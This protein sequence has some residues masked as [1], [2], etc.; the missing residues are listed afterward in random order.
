MSINTKLYIISIADHIKFKCPDKLL[1]DNTL[2]QKTGLF[3]NTVPPNKNDS[4][5]ADYIKFCV[6]GQSLKN[7]YELETIRYLINPSARHRFTE[8]DP[9]LYKDPLK[10][11]NKQ[12][13]I[14]SG[15]PIIPF[16]IENMPNNYPRSNLMWGGS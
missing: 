2:S 11:M 5:Y 13:H 3:L 7:G 15:K 12:A 10:L 8:V 16:W 14:T 6:Y 1:F 4:T 9:L